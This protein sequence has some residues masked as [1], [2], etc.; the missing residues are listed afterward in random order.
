MALEQQ[1]DARE[2]RVE[3]EDFLYHEADLLDEQ[4]LHE[5][6]G[7]LTE[8]ISYKAPVR[9]SRERAAEKSEFSENSYVFKETYESLNARTRRFDKEQ[10]WSENPPAFTRRIVGNVQVDGIDG[11]E[12]DVRS[13]LILTRKREEETTADII[14][15]QR[16]D[17][18]RWT[19]DGLKLAGRTIYLDHS[20]IN[21]RPMT[22]PL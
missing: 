19:D 4:R 12:I 1:S 21:K 22:V 16:D 17:T 20:I 6:L 18:L 5:W 14:S 15:G 7:L 2:L 11:D 13:N 8:D 9:V 3:C 10:A